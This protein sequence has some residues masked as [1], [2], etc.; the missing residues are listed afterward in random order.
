MT[1]ALVR[2]VSPLTSIIIASRL[3]ADSNE[4]S[5]QNP[6][7]SDQ[8]APND[9]DIEMMTIPSSSTIRSRRGYTSQTDEASTPTVVEQQFEED[10]RIPEEI[11]QRRRRRC[12]FR[13]SL[14]GLA[15]WVRTSPGDMQ[16]N[17]AP[18]T[19][20]DTSEDDASKDYTSEYR[21][22]YRGTKGYYFALIGLFIALAIIP[23]LV[24]MFS[25][26]FRATGLLEPA[27]TPTDWAIFYLFTISLINVL[28]W[29]IPFYLAVRM[30]QPDN[31]EALNSILFQGLAS[32][33]F[34]IAVL[35]SW[36]ESKL[37]AYL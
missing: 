3:L 34:S 30:R 20:D 4:T 29:L 33:V 27:I 37:S 6:R 21:S 35:S 32:F 14:G 13:P 28:W 31:L 1:S 10:P 12:Y 22:T 5:S 16:H 11:H 9:Y 17:I 7:M 2:A 19:T 36:G 25:L 23:W 15:R 18:P 26:I 8:P 24:S